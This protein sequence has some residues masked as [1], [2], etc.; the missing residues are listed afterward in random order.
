MVHG[1]VRQ[2]SGPDGM[3]SQSMDRAIAEC[4]RYSRTSAWL[5]R[6]MHSNTFLRYTVYLNRY[7]EIALR[8]TNGGIVNNGNS[9]HYSADQDI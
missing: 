3:S 4:C 9:K 8:T 2:I 5:N 1:G 7:A 6:R